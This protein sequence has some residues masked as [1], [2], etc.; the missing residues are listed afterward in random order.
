MLMDQD[1]GQTLAARVD[2]LVADL[3]DI[4]RKIDEGEG[5][6]GRMI[7]EPELYDQ[8]TDVVGGLSDRRFLKWVARRIRNKEIKDK[9]EIYVEELE[10]AEKAAPR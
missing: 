2:A 6:L 5:T 1:Y 3:G 7:N 10:Q 4:L 8:A 9:I